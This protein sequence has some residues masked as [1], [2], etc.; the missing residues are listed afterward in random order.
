MPFTTARPGRLGALL[1]CW[2]HL[3][4]SDQIRHVCQNEQCMWE[5]GRVSLCTSPL[6]TRLLGTNMPSARFMRSKDPVSSWRL[7]PLSPEM[8][9]EMCDTEDKRNLVHEAADMP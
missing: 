1:C 8:V 7:A 2:E 4:A 6:R 5:R 9:E 3:S